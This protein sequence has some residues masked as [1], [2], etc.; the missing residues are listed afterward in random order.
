MNL[1][2]TWRNVF[3]TNGNVMQMM[4]ANMPVLYFLFGVG[5]LFITISLMSEKRVRNIE[6]LKK[7]IKELRW[8]Y[9]SAKSEL[10]YNST[11]TQVAK[12]AFGDEVS[13]GGVPKKIRVKKSRP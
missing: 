5:M 9:M 10:M 1:R 11:Y 3:P 13:T 4:A 7:E 8:E 6:S 12:S 2:K